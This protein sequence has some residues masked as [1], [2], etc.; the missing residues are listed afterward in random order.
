MNCTG[1]L[2]SSI[3]MDYVSKKQRAKWQSLQAVTGFGWSGSAVLGGLLVDHY[4]FDICFICTA[5]VQALGWC[6]LCLLLPLVPISE[7]EVSD[8]A[9]PE[10]EGLLGAQRR[11]DFSSDT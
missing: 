2:Y 7:T 11:E 9:T 1:A 5:G 4:G 8:A 10:T 6:T 3:L